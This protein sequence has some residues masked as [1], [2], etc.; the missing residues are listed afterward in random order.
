MAMDGGVMAIG[1]TNLGATPCCGVI[2]RTWECEPRVGSITGCVHTPGA[3]GNDSGTHVRIAGEDSGPYTPNFPREQGQLSRGVCP[4][5]G[6]SFVPWL[7]EHG[8]ETRDGW[9]WDYSEAER[10]YL[11]R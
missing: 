3:Y 9:W 4:D 7:R 2:Q 5:C 8:R 6:R 10:A 1:T 11:A